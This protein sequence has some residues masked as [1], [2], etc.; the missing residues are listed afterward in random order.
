MSTSQV[1]HDGMGN[2]QL[3]GNNQLYYINREWIRSLALCF[4][5]DLCQVGISS[6]SR[7]MPLRIFSPF[8]LSAVCEERRGFNELLRETFTSPL[9]LCVVWSLMKYRAKTSV[10]KSVTQHCPIPWVCDIQNWHGFQ[11]IKPGTF[12]LRQF[13]M[14]ILYF[15]TWLFNWSP[16]SQ[17]QPVYYVRLALSSIPKH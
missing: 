5:S 3:Q 7:G 12:M 8:Q 14:I 9:I 2:N 13:C 6:H 4:S 1:G 16:I 17:I 11:D 10:V 15:R